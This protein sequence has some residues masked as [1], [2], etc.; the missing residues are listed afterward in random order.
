MMPSSF[1]QLLHNLLDHRPHTLV[2]KIDDSMKLPAVW[3]KRLICFVSLQYET[4][5]RMYHSGHRV[6]GCHRQTFWGSADLSCWPPCLWVP[7][8]LVLMP[9][10][11]ILCLQ[12]QVPQLPHCKILARYCN[13]HDLHEFSHRTHTA[14][15]CSKWQLLKFCA[16]SVSSEVCFSMTRKLRSHE[17]NKEQETVSFLWDFQNPLN[18]HLLEHVRKYLKVS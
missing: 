7:P 10:A 16:S 13:S 17:Q 11:S 5:T 1:W 14:Q 8:F 12:L 9:A 18:K 15:T 6:I 2:E 4:C 3:L